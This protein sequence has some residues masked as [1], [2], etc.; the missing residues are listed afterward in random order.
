[1]ELKLKDYIKPGEIVSFVNFRGS[2][3]NLRNNSKISYVLDEEKKDDINIQDYFEKNISSFSKS[4]FQDAC[5]MVLL[6][7]NILNKNWKDLSKT[8]N[9]RLQFVEALLTHSDTI[10]FQNYEIGFYGKDKSFY[11]KLFQKLTDRKSVV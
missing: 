1:M 7:F 3:K 11:Q 5:K 4:K 8:E 6:D 10:V 9:K 2:F